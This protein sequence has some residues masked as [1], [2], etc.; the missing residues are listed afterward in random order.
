MTDG[1]RRDAALA[2]GRVWLDPLRFGTPPVGRGM[3]GSRPSGSL[4]RQQ[5]LRVGNQCAGLD[6]GPPLRSR[7]R[8]PRPCRE[9]RCPRPQPR[10][11]QD[12]ASRLPIKFPLAASP[13]TMDLS[14]VRCR[15]AAVLA[16]PPSVAGVGARGGWGAR[17]KRSRSGVP[18][19]RVWPAAEACG[20][21]GRDG[22]AGHR[23]RRRP[24]GPRGARGGRSERL[25][26]EYKKG[27]SEK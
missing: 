8:A 15:T 12:H 18:R 4:F 27:A 22:T 14:R 24:P 10:E 7:P 11:P 26:R 6:C 5:P 1:S 9:I 25:R 2:R 21:G 13:P 20:G 17:G 23:R 16:R 19:P 3:R